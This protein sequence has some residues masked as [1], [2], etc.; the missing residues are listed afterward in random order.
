MASNH[1][2]AIPALGSGS[3]KR[4][5]VPHLS[6][7]LPPHCS[8]LSPLGWGQHMCRGTC[9]LTKQRMPVLCFHQESLPHAER[10]CCSTTQGSSHLP[11]RH[12]SGDTCC[13]G[14]VAAG[15]KSNAGAALCCTDCAQYHHP[16]H[17]CDRG[18]KDFEQKDTTVAG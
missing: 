10:S 4:P 7:P 15:D 6:P 14:K 13:Q 5:L 12:T 9:H 16:V 17:R 11:P 1:R 18:Q 2:T 8:E 3:T